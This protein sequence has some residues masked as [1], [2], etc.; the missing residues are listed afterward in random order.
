MPRRTSLVLAG[1]IGGTK[2]KLA[3]YQ[4]KDGPRRPLA[5]GTF[6]S[7]DYPSL[8]ALAGEF[9]DGKN[10]S[11]ARACFGIAGPVTNGRVRVTN[12]DWVDDESSLSAALK[13]PVHLVN[14]LVATAYAIPHLDG[15]DLLELSAGEAVPGAAYGILAPGTGLG[16]AFMVWTG[17]RYTPFPSEGGHADFAPTNP[18][19]L[20]LLHFLM[21]AHLHVSYELVCSGLGLPKLYA[22]LRDTGRF[23][24]PDWLRQKLAGS[25]DP[26]PAIVQAA[27]EGKAELCVETVRLFI[28]ILGS[29]AGN[30]ALKVYALGGVYIAGGLLDHMLPFFEEENFLQAF[31]AKGRFSDLLA[32]VPV[33]LVVNPEAGLIGAAS[34]GL[35]IGRGRD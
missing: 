4:P 22:F 23:P 26:T 18:L 16:E 35:E 3:V 31:R 11:I 5:E 21:P 27:M 15:K 17:N 8:E 24:E 33:H 7:T 34:H 20:D 1:D 32:R 25:F 9:L 6:A 28:S 13:T 14:D 30:L 29:E 19:E 12:L 10:W 2:T